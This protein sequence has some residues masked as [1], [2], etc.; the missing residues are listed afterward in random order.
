MGRRAATPTPA[1]TSPTPTGCAALYDALW[2]AGR[3]RRRGAPVDRPVRLPAG[4]RPHPLPGPR[5]RRRRATPLRRRRA[6]RRWSTYFS[7]IVDEHDHVRLGGYPGAFR[8]LLGVRTEE[9]FPLLAGEQVHPR[10][11]RPRPT[12]GPSGCT[13]PAPRCVASYHDGPLPGVPALTR[14]RVGDGTAWYLGHPARRGGHRRPGGPAAHRGR[15]PAR[16]SRP[17][18]ASRWSAAAPTTGPG[19]SW[20]TTPTPRSTL[21]ATG[22][23][24]LT[25][26]PAAGRCGCPPGR[27]PWS[28]RSRRRRGPSGDAGRSGLTATVPSSARLGGSMLAQQRQNAILELIRQRGGVRVSHL[29]SR[30]GVSD[31]TIRRDLE[32]LAERGLVDKVHGGATLAGPGSAEEPGFA[33]KSIRQQDEKTGHRRPGRPDGRAR[34][35]RRALRRHHHRRAGHPARR[36]TR[37]DRGD[38]LDPGRRR[39]LPESARRPDGRADRRH[40]HPVGRAD[41]AGGRGGDPYPATWIC[42][43]SACT[44]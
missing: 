43:F 1:S 33:A 2:R 29:V 26:S 38:Q 10:R 4:P 14:H 11:R 20:S 42:S 12:C 44:G 41:R 6:A 8:D 17:R 28:G 32:V 18:P 7:G 22:T 16:R 37:A 30:F 5:R 39:A 25:G 15:G 36:R 21:D 40:A 31:M 27:W 13:R 24:L 34:D 3:H 19:C 35:G 23:D 9:F